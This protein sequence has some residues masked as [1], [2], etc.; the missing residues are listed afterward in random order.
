MQP[1]PKKPNFPSLSQQLLWWLYCQTP[2]DGAPLGNLWPTAHKFKDSTGDN[3]TAEFQATY[4]RVSQISSLAVWLLQWLALCYP[5]ISAGRH[6]TLTHLT[7]HVLSFCQDCVPY[8]YTTQMETVMIKRDMY[9][10]FNPEIWG[11][12]P[13]NPRISGLRQIPRIPGLESLSTMPNSRYQAAGSSA[14]PD[15][16]WALC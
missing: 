7:T 4:H 14:R 1:I 10:I 3:N 5:Q 12:E 6:W 13:P 15:Y 8:T 11:L 9:E 2:I 16:T